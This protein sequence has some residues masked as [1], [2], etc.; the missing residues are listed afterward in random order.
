MRLAI[1][2]DIHSNGIAFETCLDY[3]DH[4]GIDGYVF[5]GDLL[6]D[7]PYPRRTLDLVRIAARKKQVWCVRGN[8][9]ERLIKHNDHPSEVWRSQGTTGSMLYTY[10]QMT[11]QDIDFIRRMPLT[12]VIEIPGCPLIRIAHASPTDTAAMLFPG[13][14][15]LER[16]LRN[17]KE[18]LF[19]TGHSHFQYRYESRGKQVVNP[20]S[21]GMPSF[22]QKK[23]QFALI[24]C[25]AG[26]WTARLMNIDYDKD[27]EI[28]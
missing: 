12:D 8:R 11:A 15:P 5:L 21:V 13:N 26:R 28:A 16:I 6:T 3:A 18:S 7:C 20:G 22:G 24:T 2:S 27:K 14:E 4:V 9:E 10:E 25:E 17:M 19:L 23:A 1:F